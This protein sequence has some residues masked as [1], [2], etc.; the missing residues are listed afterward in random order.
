M[1]RYIRACIIACSLISITKAMDRPP[2][3]S[4]TEPQGVRRYANI[5]VMLCQLGEIF[6]QDDPIHRRQFIALIASLKFEKL[7]ELSI[8]Q[9]PPL[10]DYLELTKLRGI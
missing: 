1:N 4:R 2:A 3:P 5:P 6:S 8:P 7:H 9:M 10:K